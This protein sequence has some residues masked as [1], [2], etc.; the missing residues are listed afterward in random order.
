MWDLGLLS[1]VQ[2]TLRQAASPFLNDI[3]AATLAT[4]HLAVRDGF[5]VLHVDRLAGHASVPVVSEVG[6]RCP[7]TPPVLARY[8]SPTLPRTSGPRCWPT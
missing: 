4:V 7:C 2:S 6:A 1:P 5:E 8:C 3:Y